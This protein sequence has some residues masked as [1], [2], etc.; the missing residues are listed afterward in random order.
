MRLKIE[1]SIFIMIDIQEKFEKAI[2][3]IETVIS[4]ASILNQASE[5]LNIPLI[6][7]EQYPKGL[8]K[9]I[10][11]IY[12]PETCNYFEKT[13]FSIFTQEITDYLKSLNR[14]TLILYGIEAHICL[15]QSA[16]DA[17]DE[18]YQVFYVCD[19]VASRKE[20]NKK[21]AIKRL[22]QNGIE[23]INTEMLLFELVNDA[24]HPNFKQISALVK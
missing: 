8:G 12:L 14:K 21:I 9:T 20:S 2:P 18:G 3:D 6:V 5:F 22:I 1:E 4:N 10:N 15:T 13:R 24:K 16:L 17:L 19:A 7:T 11:R 23:M